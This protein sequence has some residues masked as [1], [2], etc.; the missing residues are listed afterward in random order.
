MNGE[1]SIAGAAPDRAPAARAP[2]PSRVRATAILLIVLGALGA[3][4]SVFVLSEQG[5][6]ESSVSP[7]EFL[8]YFVQVVASALLIACG[9]FLL[10]GRE[11]ARLGG[12]ILCGLNILGG[13]ITL[14][15]GGVVPAL[16]AIVLNLA[17]IINLARPEVQRWCTS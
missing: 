9:V 12:M 1:E 2:M 16:V 3:G 6:H 4:L 8:P 11:W 5:S 10:R 15:A 17:L 13:V 7:A 14:S